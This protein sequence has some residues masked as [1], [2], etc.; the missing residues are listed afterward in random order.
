MYKQFK[1]CSLNNLVWITHNSAALI[2]NYHPCMIN[3]CKIIINVVRCRDG[4]VPK[5]RGMRQG[6]PSELQGHQS[7]LFHKSYVMFTVIMCVQLLKRSCL[8]ELNTHYHILR[9]IFCKQA[10]HFVYSISN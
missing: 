3:K 10:K 9:R 6:C 2:I 5:R 4:T 8:S 1:N 7:F